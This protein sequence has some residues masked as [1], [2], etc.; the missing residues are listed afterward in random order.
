ML[1]LAA[2]AVL[3]ASADPDDYRKSFPKQDSLVTGIYDGPFNRDQ[4]LIFAKGAKRCGICGHGV[5]DANG[6]A[7]YRQDAFRISPNKW[8]PEGREYL[9]K[10]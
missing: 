6:G 10:A 5:I 9:L 8:K 4:R 3:R 7:F 1:E 2:G